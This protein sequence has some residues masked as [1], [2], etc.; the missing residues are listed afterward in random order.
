MAYTPFA[1]N[2]P[3]ASDNGLQVI[4]DARI[5]LM[6]MRDAVSMG[7][8]P[9]W[10]Y[11]K[12]DGAG[13]AEQPQYI[14]WSKGTERL[15]ATLTWGTTGGADGNVTASVWQYSSNS[16]SSWDI[17]GTESITYDASGNVV[18]SSWT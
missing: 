17:I 5:N 18:S 6:A 16:G 4:D 15:R 8:M 10:A 2:K 14:M 3:V 1:D 7:A 13:S 9:G 12:T 11:S